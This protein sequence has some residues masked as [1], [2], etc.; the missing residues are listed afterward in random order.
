MRRV[1]QHH[2]RT[3]VQPHHYLHDGEADVHRR[4]EPEAPTRYFAM[5]V[6]VMVVRRAHDAT[7][8]VASALPAIAAAKPA[9]SSNACASRASANS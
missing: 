2:H 1:G 4:R 5:V 8:S 9:R 6:T 7:P 3:R